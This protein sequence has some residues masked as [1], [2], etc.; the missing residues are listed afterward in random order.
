MSIKI[1]NCMERN[2]LLISLR[3]HMLY[4]NALH[5][6]SINKIYRYDNIYFLY[7]LVLTKLI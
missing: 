3:T 5:K 4:I 7:W 2:K 1:I 6:T